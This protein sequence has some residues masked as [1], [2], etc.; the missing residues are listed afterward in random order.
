[1]RLIDTDKLKK[2]YEWWKDGTEEHTLDEMR[3]I[4]NTIV[5]LQPTIDPVKRGAWEI[6]EAYPHNV[7][8]S[9]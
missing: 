3:E 5:D 4:F 7:H 2:H 8:C 9:V 1:M 6:T